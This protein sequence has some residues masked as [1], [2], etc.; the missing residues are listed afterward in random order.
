[1][2]AFNSQKLY[3]IGSQC[4]EKCTTKIGCQL[5]KG[6]I[7]EKTC[8]A[9]RDGEEYKNSKCV[10]ICNS[11]QIFENGK[12]VRPSCPRNSYWDRKLL[13]CTCYIDNQHVIDGECQKCPKDQLWDSSSKSC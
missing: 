13:Q 10:S 11:N 5:V 4:Q 3:C 8:F 6:E 9:C 2:L 7:N 1:M 12:C